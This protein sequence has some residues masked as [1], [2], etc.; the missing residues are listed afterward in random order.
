V[1]EYDDFDFEDYE[2][3]SPD[4]REE[5]ARET[6][7]EFFESNPERV[8]FSRQ[9]EV[10]HED[11]YFH[12]ISN[13]AIRGLLGEGTIHGETRKLSTGGTINLI[14]HR[15]YRYYRRVAKQLVELVEEYAD[16]NIGGALGLHGE[17]MVL[18]AFARAEFVMR[19]HNTHE[20]RGKIWEESEHDLDFIFERDSIVYGIEV[21]NTLGYMQYK[22]LD[23]K[24]RL[25]RYLGV[26]AL[27][28]VRMMPKT[29]IKELIDSGG[30]AM[31][32]KYQLYPWT[33]REL[34]SK[35]AGQLGL[36]VDAPRALASGTMERFL[37]WHGK[38]L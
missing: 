1:S 36:P 35:V 23:I 18:T 29:W 7:R 34:A 31:V 37:R 16:P 4:V 9:I 24:I 19:G 8:F 5:A 6:L 3:R 38:N 22:E 2:E 28:V 25:C 15:G 17:T 30:Y 12:W 27:F 11:K 10:M 14:W 13:R 21:K 32:L 33:H 20:F 26:R